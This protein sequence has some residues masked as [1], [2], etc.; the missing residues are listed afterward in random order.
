[1]RHRVILPLHVMERRYIKAVV[2]HV[3]GNVSRAADILGMGRTTLWRRLKM[4][5]YNFDTK[6]FPETR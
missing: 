1:M 5:G 2:E 3:Y 6:R 4:Y